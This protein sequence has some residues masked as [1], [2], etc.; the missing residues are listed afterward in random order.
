MTDARGRAVQGY[1]PFVPPETTRSDMR[2]Y[3]SML[4]GKPKPHLGRSERLRR[5]ED[6]MGPHIRRL[7][8][9]RPLTGAL[10]ETLRICYPTGGEHA[11]GE[12]MTEWPD[13]G[14]WAEM[15]NW[16]CQARGVMDGSAHVT[17][18]RLQKVWADPPGVYVKIEELR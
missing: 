2:A 12:A 1:L 16:M 7:R 8:P 10:R 17:E 6:L 15:F 18:M 14:G 3:V 4:N 9:D 11:Q 5:A 13:L